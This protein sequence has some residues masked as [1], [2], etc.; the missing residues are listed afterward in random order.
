MN[1]VFN[2]V[3]MLLFL[4]DGFYEEQSRWLN[5]GLADGLEDSVFFEKVLLYG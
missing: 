3:D 1:Y 2:E 5:V 4:I